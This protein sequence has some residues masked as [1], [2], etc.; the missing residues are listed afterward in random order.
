[1][2][3]ETEVVE[4]RQI[5]LTP[6]RMYEPGQYR[7]SDLPDIAFEM[8]LVEKLPAILSQSEGADDPPQPES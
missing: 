6:G 1:M 8:G 4:L 3:L 2:F 7:V 5:C